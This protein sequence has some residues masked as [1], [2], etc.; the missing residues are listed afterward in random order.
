[1]KYTTTIDIEKPL[2]EV[3][4]LFDNPDHYAEWMNGFEGIEY[5]EG[6]PGQV[7][8]KA[9]LVFTVKKRT[10]KMS[11]VVMVRNL[12]EEYTV[13]YEANGV[14]NTVKNSFVALDEN[15]TRYTT[16][17]EFTFSGMMRIIAFL[18]PGA[19]KKQSLR[20]MTDFKTFVEST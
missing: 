9:N 12:P 13:A 2:P 8:T 14:Y 18:M 6:A 19:F 1:M 7:G 11:E 16:E 15:T 5:V 20:Y 3:V 4:A 10:M 17:H